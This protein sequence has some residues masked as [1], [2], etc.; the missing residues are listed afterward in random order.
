M[1]EV[2]LSPQAQ[3]YYRRAPEDLARRLSEAFKALEQ[4]PTP[5]GFKRLKGQFVGLL[6]LRVGDYRI[7]YKVL[8]EQK[9]IKVAYIGPRGDAY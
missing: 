1:F 6:R 5:P 9:L 2:K 7:I 8:H 4:S 3:S